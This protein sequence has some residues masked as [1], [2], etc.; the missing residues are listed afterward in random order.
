MKIESCHWCHNTIKDFEGTWFDNYGEEFC[1]FHPVTHDLK[2]S[3][4]V[5]KP[6]RHESECEVYEYVRKLYAIPTTRRIDDNVVSI[7]SKSRSTSKNAAQ[8]ILPR[9]GSMRR[10][11][12]NQVQ[13]N[14]GLTDYELETLL[15]G[16]HQTV[17]AS[18]R[19]LVVDGFLFD[20][21]MTRKNEVGNDCIVWEITMK[22][23]LFG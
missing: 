3:Q 12:Y 9:T 2:T 15:Q 8:K 5:G 21:G 16:K 4:Q 6:H 22:E 7:S 1:R 11:I 13:R 17:S 14:N 20:S 10:E 19:S 18:R 23:T